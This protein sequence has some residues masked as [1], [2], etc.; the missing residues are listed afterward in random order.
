MLKHSCMLG[1]WIEWT[2]RPRW[3]PGL[4]FISKTIGTA[5]VPSTKGTEI[6][7]MEKRLRGIQ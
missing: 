6:A 2:W 4:V 7:M 1:K 3:K 5:S